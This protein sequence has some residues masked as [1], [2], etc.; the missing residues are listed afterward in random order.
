MT[1]HCPHAA[2]MGLTHGVAR[3]LGGSRLTLVAG[4]A[5]AAAEARRSGA[6]PGYCR[7]IGL[8]L[9]KRTNCH[10]QWHHRSGEFLWS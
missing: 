8:I 5:G 7:T 1:C 6:L 2:A 3:R 9:G 4:R 10:E